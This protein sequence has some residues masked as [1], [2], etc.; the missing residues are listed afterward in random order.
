M[1]NAESTGAA[2]AE[3]VEGSG[4]TKEQ[5]LEAMNSKIANRPFGNVGMER[6]GDKKIL[7]QFYKL[8]YKGMKVKLFMYA[9]ETVSNNHTNHNHHHQATTLMAV[10]AERR[11]ASAASLAHATHLLHARPPSPSPCPPHW[12]LRR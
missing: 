3:T 8:F 1:G 4:L 5:S 12:Q 7:S 9:D 10:H 2:V 11:T 6:I